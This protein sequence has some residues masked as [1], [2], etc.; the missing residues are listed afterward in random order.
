A[1]GGGRRKGRGVVFAV[2][3]A[4][5]LLLAIVGVK[6]ML[7]RGGDSEAGEARVTAVPVK[8][9]DPAPD[10][11]PQPQA[12]TPQPEATNPPPTQPEKTIAEPA[13]NP[14][15]SAEPAPRAAAAPESPAPKPAKRR[16]T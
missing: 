11:A 16:A 15:P 7:G 13:E 6:F 4:A 3:G 2:L 1:L 12:P 14:A 10:P 5:A 8:A 9:A